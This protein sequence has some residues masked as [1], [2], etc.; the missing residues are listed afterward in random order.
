MA[1]PAAPLQYS[2]CSLSRGQTVTSERLLLQPILIRSVSSNRRCLR[3][4]ATE[5]TSGQQKAQPGEDTRIHWENEDEGWIGGSYSN[6]RKKLEPEEKKQDLL[7][8][9]FSELLNSSTDSHYQ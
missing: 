2:F 3:V 9:N 6:S 1:L 7:D 5:T 8:E 4:F